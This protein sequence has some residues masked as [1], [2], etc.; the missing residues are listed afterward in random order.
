[1]YSDLENSLDEIVS[2]LDVS[3]DW[4]HTQSVFISLKTT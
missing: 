4:Q 2:I 3:I 1:M